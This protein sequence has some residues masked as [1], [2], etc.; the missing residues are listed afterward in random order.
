[1][2]EAGQFF[3]KP[4]LCLSGS[5][6]GGPLLAICGKILRHEVGQTGK[7]TAGIVVV[8]VDPVLIEG[9]GRRP[10]RIK[11]DRTACGLAHLRAV[12][13]R[14]E[15]AG[16]AMHVAGSEPAAKFDAGRDV[17]PLIAAADLHAAVEHVG[18]V[19]EVPR[20]QKHVA[21]LGVGKTTIAVE[22][23]LHRILG[24]H[25]RERHVLAN[26]PQEFEVADTPHPV[27]IVD[28]VHPLA[29][30]REDAAN[31]SLDAGDVGGEFL[32]REQ[33][34]LLAAAARVADHAGGPA[35]HGD[36]LVA[37]GGYAAEEHEGHEMPH[38]QAVGGGIEA[39]IDAAARRGEPL[40]KRRGVGGLVDE[41]ASLEVGKKISRHRYRH[42]SS[43]AKG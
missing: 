34:A 12:G 11:P 8:E 19:N 30:A 40:A 24:E 14:Q 1:M 6:S 17:A 32:G 38:M 26:V 29:G 16:D 22:T 31:L 23:T 28:D 42:R 13:L 9:I 43:P 5:W 15:W 36:R 21:E 25:L 27:G 18:E 4:L 3:G 33:V 20:L 37:G 35:E 41:A 2:N 10:P 7:A 39:G